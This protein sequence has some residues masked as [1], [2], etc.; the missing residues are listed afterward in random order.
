MFII[1]TKASSVPPIYSAIATAASLPDAIAIP[2][3]I[4]STV[5]T[6]PVSRSIV[7]PPIFLAFSLAVILSLNDIL[8]LSTASIAI[9]IVIILVTDAGANFSWAFFSYTIFPEEV[10]I[11]IAD[12]ASTCISSLHCTSFGRHIIEV[13]AINIFATVL[14]NLLFIMHFLLSHIF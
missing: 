13:A 8:P 14:L 7:L 11:N 3:S 10:S 5:L 2:L 6:S 9:S 4:S 1:S 12:L